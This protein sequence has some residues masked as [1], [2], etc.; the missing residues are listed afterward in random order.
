MSNLPNQNFDRLM[1]LLAANAV[2]AISGD[3]QRE[4]DQL[5]AALP[6]DSRGRTAD[7]TQI[8]RTIGA[9]IAGFHEVVVADRM[10]MPGAVRD[11]MTSRGGTMVGS[12]GGAAPATPAVTPK[13]GSLPWIG[14]TIAAALAI[15]AVIGWMRQPP[16]AVVPPVPVPLTLT[17]QR[18]ELI[19][20]QADTLQRTFGATE[21]PAAQGVSGDVVW[22][23]RLQQG[24]LRFRG[25]AANDPAELQYQLWIFDAGRPDGM[26]FPV[27]GGVFDVAA[28]QTDPAT[29]EIIIP[30]NAKLDVVDPAA[31]AVT[32]E[33]PG[34]VVVT[35]RERVLVLAAVDG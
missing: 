18:Q 16:A 1:D 33:R 19:A 7:P 11:R 34:G 3:E 12:R 35:K 23:N 26:E 29:G 14:W 24:Y 20:N 25:L 17:E 32:I 5:L 2:D 27:D 4:L 6:T 28:A 15:V 10:A 9:L 22:N 30:I 21:D 13:A 31:F 8:D